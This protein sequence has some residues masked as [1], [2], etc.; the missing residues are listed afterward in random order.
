MDRKSHESDGQAW[1]V[2]E[3]GHRKELWRSHCF[4]PGRASKQ[5]SWHRPLGQDDIFQSGQN[6]P[7]RNCLLE[8]GLEGTAQWSLSSTPLCHPLQGAYGSRV[9]GLDRER[10]LV[11]L[12]QA[13]FWASRGF[14]GSWWLVSRKL[15]CVRVSLASFAGSLQRALVVSWDITSSSFQ[16]SLT[17]SRV[18]L[19]FSCCSAWA[20]LHAVISLSVS[21]CVDLALFL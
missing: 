7:S 11:K 19:A 12:S 17:T 6:R 18:L 10:V 16:E 20:S 14:C 8:S 15:E 21:N 1:G 13:W 3:A 4:C 9:S 2:R 5:V